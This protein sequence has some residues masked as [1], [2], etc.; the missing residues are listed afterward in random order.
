ME[1]VEPIR[2]V[3]QIDAMKKLMIADENYRD[4][5]LFTLGINS[6]LRVSDLLSIKWQLFLNDKGKLLKGGSAIIVTEKKTGKAKRF[7]LNKSIRKAVESS[8]ETFESVDPE[9]FVF[10]S[11]QSDSEGQKM[12]ISRVQAWRT[13]NKYARAVGIR[14]K[15]GTHTLRKTFGYHLYKK[16]IAV[17]Y[18][19]KLLNHS[20]ASITLRY[21][22]ISQDQL[23]EIYVDLNL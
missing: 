1:F 22:G 4:H 11:R 2:D 5:L 12:P 6:G 18:I 8:H 10:L 13:L 3:K 20:A 7:K 21:I 23:D 19:Q 9:A 15:I 14:D 16:G 17:E